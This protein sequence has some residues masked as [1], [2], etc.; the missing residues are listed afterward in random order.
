[1]KEDQEEFIR[2][3]NEENRKRLRE[4][5]RGS[6]EKMNEYFREQDELGTIGLDFAKTRAQ[7]IK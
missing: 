2:R 1:M 5:R 6:R 4:K 7:K 3:R